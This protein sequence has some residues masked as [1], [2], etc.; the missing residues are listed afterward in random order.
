M[1]QEAGRVDEHGMTTDRGDDRNAFAVKLLAEVDDL[2]DAG[3]E[4]GL[5]ERLVDANSH[6]LEVAAGKA[7]VSV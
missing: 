5:A 2:T 7:A 1:G 3:S 6:G 4:V